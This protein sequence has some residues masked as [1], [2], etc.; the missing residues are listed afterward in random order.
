MKTEDAIMQIYKACKEV[1]PELNAKEHVSDL[2]FNILA[3]LE[4]DQK[5]ITPKKIEQKIYEHALFAQRCVRKK[6][7][8]A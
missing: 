4:L 3:D 8:A 2:I 7:R 6:R 5:K 1:S